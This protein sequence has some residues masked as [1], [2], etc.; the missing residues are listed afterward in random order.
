MGWL[1]DQVVLVTGGGSGLGR[2][3]T[4]RFVDEG[5]SV[6][7]LD[8]D[9][10]RLETLESEFDDSVT[11]IV[12]DVTE[13]ADNERAVSETVDAFGKLDVFV[14]NAGVFDQNTA[15]SELSGDQL[16]E[17]FVELFNVN[18]LG[19]MMGAKA[20][21]PELLETDGRMVFTASQASFGS[22]GG[23]ILYV[24][25]KHAVAGL[26]RQLAFELAPSVRVNAVAPGFVPTDL[27]G[28]ETLGGDRGVV[29]AEEFDPT[30]HPLEITPSAADYTGPYVLLASRENSRPMTGTI[31]RADLGR[32]VRGITEVSRSAVEYV[33]EDIDR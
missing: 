31:V 12:G 4:E 11:T 9:E 22:D 5:A 23:G 15:L 13:L 29:S 6:G 1:S 24:P 27:S 26:V 18:V 7:V 16:E 30:N 10:D 2:A 19:Y 33:T 32:S 20:A 3:V 21:L 14:G 28:T 25:S 17:S 8:I